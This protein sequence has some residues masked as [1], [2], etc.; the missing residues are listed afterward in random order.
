MRVRVRVRLRVRV[1][2]RVGF[3]VRVRVR[4]RVKVKVKVRVHVRVGE[5]GDTRTRPHGRTLQLIER[6]KI[7][8]LGTL[9][10]ASQRHTSGQQCFRVVLIGRP[11]QPLLCFGRVKPR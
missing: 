7:I 6:P 2:V 8:S 9:L 10:S 1:R 11:L 3:R 4:V 5:G